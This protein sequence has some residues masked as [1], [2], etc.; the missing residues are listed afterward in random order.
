MTDTCKECKYKDLCEELGYD[1]ECTDQGECERY[2][3][4][5]EGAEMFDCS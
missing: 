3:E 5:L 1:L 2:Y 4:Y